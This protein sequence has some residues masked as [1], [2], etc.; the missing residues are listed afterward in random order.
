M[1]RR[2]IL[3]AAVVL[4]AVA[5]CVE[6]SA[7]DASAWRI[8]TSPDLPGCGL[9]DVARVP[10]HSGLWA[11]G[12]CDTSTPLIEHRGAGA[13][14]TVVPAPAVEGSTDSQLLGIA[15][16]SRD[17]VWAV[18]TM[19]LAG[20][21]PIYATLVEHWDG[22]SW[23]QVPSPSPGNR[24]NLLTSIVAASPTQ[25]W[26]VGSSQNTGEPTRPLVLHWTASGWRTVDVPVTRRS[27]FLSAV[28]LVPGTTNRLWAFGGYQTARPG[29]HHPLVLHRGAHGWVLSKPP[30]HAG[31]VFNAGLVVRRRGRDTV[32]AAGKDGL[33]ERTTGTGWH[34]VRTPDP[35]ASF[36][37]LAR[38]PG[39]PHL[40]AVGGNGFGDH[41]VSERWNGR[42]W[43]EVPTPG[44]H[45]LGGVVALSRRDV[46]AV[47]WF[48]A[49]AGSGNA[50][51][52]H[53]H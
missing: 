43:V 16:I 41:N 10:G 45:G 5:A 21:P 8:A 13:P 34:I 46:W 39:T 2:L 30:C 31:N 48:G 23:T 9:S 17:D 29:R 53:Y 1:L 24:L 20:G 52:L 19:R 15:A 35:Q 38:T 37:A 22:A 11:A 26:A 14:W 51:I 6:T 4:T 49:V 36:S 3:L 28:S 40:W 25:L 33:I 47:G 18:G 12:D 7:A 32:W 44:R 27:A 42:R 50:L